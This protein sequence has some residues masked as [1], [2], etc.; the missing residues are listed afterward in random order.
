MGERKQKSIGQILIDKG[1]VT[2]EQV[3]QAL[4]MQ[5]ANPK[6]RLGEALVQMQAA[7]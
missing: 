3:A 2:E 6:I 5:R 7:N 4:E 1:V